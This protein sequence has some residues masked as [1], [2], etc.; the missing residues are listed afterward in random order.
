MPA[1]LIVA[2]VAGRLSS[3]VPA[4]AWFESPWLCALVYAD[5]FTR[6]AIHECGEAFLRFPHKVFLGRKR[7]EV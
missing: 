6:D 2:N 1:Q 7:R 5:E 4:G 3:Y